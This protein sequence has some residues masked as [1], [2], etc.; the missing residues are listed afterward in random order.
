MV[1]SD[2]Q[3]LTELAEAL[4]SIEPT[5]AREREEVARVDEALAEAEKAAQTADGS[6]ESFTQQAALPKQQ[7]EVQQGRKAN[8]ERN[9]ATLTQRLDRIGQEIESLRSHEETTS[10]DA[11]VES[12]PKAEAA[13]T[14]QRNDLELSRQVLV[15]S[16]DQ[17]GRKRKEQD[18]LRRQ[19]Q[20]LAG[21]RAS[22]EALQ[23]DARDEDAEDQAN[24]WLQKTLSSQ[25]SALLDLVSVKRG[26][27]SAADLVL[28]EWLS[29]I[30]ADFENMPAEPSQPP[31]GVSLI[32]S[33]LSEVSADPTMLLHYISGPAGIEDVLTGV[34]V[35]KTWQ[36][37]IAARSHLL[38]WQSVVS[39][40]GLWVG[41]SWMRSRTQAD[42]EQGIIA[43]QGRLAEIIHEFERVSTQLAEVD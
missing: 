16:R 11:I 28:A 4:A 29:S 34:R 39:Q 30:G 12:L 36:E 26:Y 32:D 9:L 35:V 7:V 14:L 1:D 2:S 21:Q 17:L 19:S 37:A 31:S 5:L 13:G 22:L 10:L 6:W 24:S 15:D 3:R 27:E 41:R 38:S 20:V 42:A 43:R 25:G 18:E 33:T 23:S 8:A 40:D